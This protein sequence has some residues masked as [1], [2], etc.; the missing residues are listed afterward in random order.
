MISPPPASNVR[1]PPISNVKSP[2]SDI[3]EPFK[4]ISSTTTQVRPVRPLSRFNVT[5]PD[6]PPPLRFVPAV[7]PVISPDPLLSSWV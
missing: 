5:L 3:V 1:S 7:T 6:D 4:V 2:L